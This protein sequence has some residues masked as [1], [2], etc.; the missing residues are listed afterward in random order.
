MPIS[1]FW[2]LYLQNLTTCH[3]LHC[4]HSDLSHRCFL[5]RF[6]WL[7]PNCSPCF[8]P[9]SLVFCFLHNSK[10][11]PFKTNDIVKHKSFLQ[12]L[13]ISLRIKVYEDLQGLTSSTLCTPTSLTYLLHLPLGSLYSA[14]LVS[15]NK[16]TP[17]SGPLHLLYPSPG[18][19]L[20]L[21]FV[22]LAPSLLLCLSSGSPFWP[23]FLS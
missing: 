4:C 20:P 22:W 23:P 17:V 5:P 1:K 8:Y 7:P 3:H 21:I 13:S 14:T 11:Q 9:Y 18:M 6:L 15:F 19:L 16:E 2:H 12:R 10:N